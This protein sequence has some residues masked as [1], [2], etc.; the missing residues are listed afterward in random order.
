MKAMLCF[1]CLLCA[2]AGAAAAEPDPELVR[3]WNDP[4]FKKYFL[5]TYGIHADVEPKLGPEQRDLLEKVYPLLAS[6]PDTAVKMLEDAVATPEERAAAEAESG[7]K[8][9]RK[10][11]AAAG[12]ASV[13]PAD[14]A[15]FEFILGNIAFQKDQADEAIRRYQLAVTKFPN[16]RRAHKNL[17]LAQVRAGNVDA[18]ITSF[19]KMIELGGGDAVSYG[20]L[21]YAFSAKSD[22][23]AAE[24]AYRNALLLD[25]QNQEWRLGLA[26]AVQRQQKHEEAAALLHVLLERYPERH[27]FWLLQANAFLGMKQPL[28]A[29]ENLEVVYKMDKA[30]PE[31]MYLL[32]DIYTNES[33][34]DL[35]ASA[36][37][38]G[39]ELDPTQEPARVLR[40]MDGLAAR[41]ANEEAQAVS[42]KIRAAFGDRL[43]D[44][45]KRR[46]LK[47]D[48]RVAAASGDSGESARVLEEIVALD[49][50]D[51]DALILLGQHYARSGDPERARVLYER[52]ANVEA[53]EGPAK[54]RL[55]QLLVQQGKYDEALPLLKRAQEIKPQEEIARYIDQVE[56]VARSRR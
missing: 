43:T 55:G 37:G 36:Y 33:R 40:A 16:F 29:A 35:A 20:L 23:L 28:R 32:G 52:A 45:D 56:R 15:L 19:T 14:T 11:K 12:A 53:F 25:P 27:E 48:A 13:N 7:K 46:L 5:G 17:G 50:F 30:T 54:M 49:P 2:A 31:V 51:G 22:F 9:R 47:L 21:G 10:K 24:A 18:A 4:E 42:V 39:V 38:R 8:S 34:P 41:G 44:A 1:A 6:D 3:I 26:R